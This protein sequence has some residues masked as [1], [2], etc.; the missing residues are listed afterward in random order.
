VLGTGSISLTLLLHEVFITISLVGSGIMK[1]MVHI[2]RVQWSL[3]YQY[4]TPYDQQKIP[5]FREYKPHFYLTRIYPPKLGCSLCTEHYVLLTTEP[6]TPVLCVVK[7]PVETASVWDL[8][9]KLL[10]THECANVLP[11]YWHNLITW[12]QLTPSIPR[13]QK[14]VTSLTN[15]RKYC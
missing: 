2:F 10:H 11:V 9:C 8:S 7:L 6:A 4:F 13:R 15:Y 5:N 1:N 3:L 12:E 14:T